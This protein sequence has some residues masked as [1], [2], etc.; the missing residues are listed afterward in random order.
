MIEILSKKTLDDN[1]IL[2]SF[3]VVSFFINLLI[4]FA[5]DSISNRWPAIS[6]YAIFQKTNFFISLQ[7]VLNSSFLIIL[8]IDKNLECSPLSSIIA[9][10]ILQDLE[11][12]ALNT[13]AFHIPFYVQYV[14]DI[15]MGA[16]AKKK[17]KY[18]KFSIRFNFDYSSRLKLWRQIKLFRYYYYQD[19]NILV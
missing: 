12:K 9:D 15:A 8:S 14:D 17:Q 2:I 4:D 7:L 1:S 19:N 13:L 6:K 3:D 16:P 5:L 18:Y 10:L 11:K